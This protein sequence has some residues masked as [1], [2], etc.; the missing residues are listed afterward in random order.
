MESLK[1]IG[2]FNTLDKVKYGSDKKKRPYFGFTPF[3]SEIKKVKITYSGK[4]KGK[5]LAQ[6]ELLN[7]DTFPI[8]RIHQVI[9]EYNEKNIVP[10]LLQYSEQK[11]KDNMVKKR[12]KIGRLQ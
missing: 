6:I 2:Y 11:Y 1:L 3:N 4:F 10:L 8:G 7:N 9:G 12:D 5:L